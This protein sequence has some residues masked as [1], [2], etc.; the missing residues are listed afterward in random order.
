MLAGDLPVPASEGVQA[1]VMLVVD[2][3]VK[4]LDLLTT[5]CV[6]GWDLHVLVERHKQDNDSLL[7]TE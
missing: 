4:S 5:L 2:I 3:V 7:Q 6:C 1:R